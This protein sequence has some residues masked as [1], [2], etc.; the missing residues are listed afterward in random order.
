MALAVA[1]KKFRELGSCFVL[2]VE[3]MAL[4]KFLLVA[5]VSEVESG[6]TRIDGGLLKIIINE[7]DSLLQP[8]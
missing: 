7:T 3:V 1:V 4:R 5:C 6:E 8:P 2:F